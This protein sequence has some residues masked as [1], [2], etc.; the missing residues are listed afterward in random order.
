VGRVSAW[1]RRIWQRVT[2]RR[3]LAVLGACLASAVLLRVSFPVP[4]WHALAWV[5][6]VPWLV[7]VRSGSGREA[8]WGS[9]AMGLVASLL[10]LSWQLLVTVV[11]GV[12]LAGYVGL[13][14]VLFAWLVRVARARLRQ[15]FVLAAPLVW[16]GCEY[17]RSFAL[18]GFPW[19]FVGHTQVP[20]RALVQV[21][22]LLGAYALSFVVVA[23]NA[24][25]AEAIVAWRA[26][27]RGWPRLAA[28]A[29]F[30]AALVGAAAGYGAWRL[31]RVSSREGPRVAIVQANVPQEIKNVVT[32]ESVADITMKHVRTTCELAAGPGGEA[33]DLV[34]WPETMI[35]WPL[36]WLH[37][38]GYPDP[39]PELAK[40]AARHGVAL[41]P[42][43]TRHFHGLLWWLADR[44]GCPVLVGAHTKVGRDGTLT[45]PHDGTVDR[46]APDGIVLSGRPYPL[47]VDE[48]PLTGE[49]PGRVFHVRQGDRVAEGDPV[50]TYD[51][52]PHNSAYLFRPGGQG[53]PMERYDK[54]H[55]VPFG[56]YVPLDEY[57][58]FLLVAVPY[59]KGFQPGRRAVLMEVAG[60]RFGVLIC[61]EDV[62]P[63]LVRRFVVR[64]DGG[65]AD[66]LINIS[67]DGWFKGSHE[68]DQHLAMCRL[69]AVE[70]RTGIVRCC[71]TGISAIIDPDG[72]IQT[73]VRDERG[74]RKN[75]H[76][77]A[78]GRVRLRAELTFYARHGDLL[79]Q[80][81][82]AITAVAFLAAVLPPLLARLR[83]RACKDG[84]CPV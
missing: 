71:N 25:V 59:R 31:P 15:P 61:F 38:P 19:Y 41:P 23:A 65:G 54:I 7:V 51:S 67:N 79:G 21:S 35:Q 30:V 60:S 47:P 78:I 11:G 63:R 12:L 55:L 46:L 57:L 75:V 39:G 76:G 32:A 62:F 69:R 68:L 26:R 6:L 84:V 1:L 18:T 33:L 17:L 74:R 13:Y 42:G 16:V 4:G 10:G 20:V 24:W 14:F 29:A 43:A 58:A 8:V 2:T 56:E 45:A 5:A 70:F 77:A 27:P 49:T 22:D 80:G 3:S 36:N 81:C 9:V 34:V 64:Q 83:R 53:G 50:V 40:A 82:L 48:D 72:S 44:M 66:F 73:I 52:V 37:A 28:G